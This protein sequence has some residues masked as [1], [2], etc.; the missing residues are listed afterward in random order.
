MAA[1]EEALEATGVCACP[2]LA[3]GVWGTEVEGS[4]ARAEGSDLGPP[5]C[6]V[7]HW[8]A[9]TLLQPTPAS[10]Q[11]QLILQPHGPLTLNIRINGRAYKESVTLSP[12]P[13]QLIWNFWKWVHHRHLAF[14]S[15]DHRRGPSAQPGLRASAN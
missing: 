3:Q 5:Q 14:F 6:R 13:E 7:L 1:I 11:D 15:G 12:I 9:S 4:P 8:A 10:V 2:S